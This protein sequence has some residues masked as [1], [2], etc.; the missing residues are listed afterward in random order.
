MVPALSFA[1]Q[2]KVF[3]DSINGSFIDIDRV[4][5]K[6]DIIKITE[7]IEK[8]PSTEKPTQNKDKPNI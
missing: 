6:R 3:F 1:P 4:S 7:R 8:I 2:D 5:N